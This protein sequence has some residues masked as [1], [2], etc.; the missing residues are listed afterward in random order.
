MGTILAFDNTGR[1]TSHSG[2]VARQVRVPLLPISSAN[3]GAARDHGHHHGIIHAA[4]R[5]TE[6]VRAPRK[7]GVQQSVA[8]SHSLRARSVYTRKQWRRFDRL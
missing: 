4:S 1:L 7:A 6:G 3:S 5:Q 8:S 2:K